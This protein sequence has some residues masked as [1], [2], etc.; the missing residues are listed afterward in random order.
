[1]QPLNPLNRDSDLFFVLF[2]SYLLAVDFMLVSLMEAK[3]FFA[4]LG[5]K[6][7]FQV[8]RKRWRDLKRE[9]PA[10]F[11]LLYPKRKS[12]SKRFMQ[13]TFSFMSF[14]PELGHMASP[15]D[16]LHGIMLS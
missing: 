7:T 4:T 1:M 8:E 6:D 14:W 5:I 16:Q 13:L 15:R 10:L 9:Q 11:I 2:H 3:W 12:F